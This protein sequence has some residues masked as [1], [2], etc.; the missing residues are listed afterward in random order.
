MLFAALLLLAAAPAAL[1]QTYI[2]SCGGTFNLTKF[3]VTPPNPQAGDT[4]VMNVTGTETGAPLAGGTGV[5]N[6]YLFGAEV[7][8]A[9]FAVRPRSQTALP[10]TSKAATSFTALRS[11]PSAAPCADLQPDHH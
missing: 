8:T 5:I 6:A 1:A 2:S 9:P 3:A 4:V 10:P 11:L 7:F